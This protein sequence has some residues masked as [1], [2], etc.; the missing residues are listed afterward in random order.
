VIVDRARVVLALQDVGRGRNKAGQ[1]PT[2]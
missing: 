2:N 1:Q